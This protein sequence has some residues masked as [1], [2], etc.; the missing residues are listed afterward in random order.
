MYQSVKLLLSILVFLSVSQ[1]LYSQNM[2]TIS[3]Y[4]IVY[5]KPIYGVMVFENSQFLSVS[6]QEGKC[7]INK[8]VK[9]I[10]C[11]YPG[12]NDTLISITGNENCDIFLEANYNL[13]K[14]VEVDAKYD[15]KKHLIRLLKESQQTAYKIDTVLYYS[16]V[17]VNTLTDTNQVEILSGI[18]R[19]ENKG[20]SKK[21]NLTFLSGINNYYN[22]IN[23]ELYPQLRTSKIF[24]TLFFNILYPAR[25]KKLKNKYEIENPIQIGKDSLC[26]PVY[27]KNKDVSTDFNVINFVNKKISSREFAVQI[28]NNDRLNKSYSRTDYLISPISIPK[29]INS[30]RSFLL[31]NGETV[32]NSIELNLIEDPGIKEELSVFIFNSS[33]QKLVEIAKIKFPDIVIPSKKAL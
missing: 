27:S 6:N 2:R 13:I 29:Y 11:K 5:E 33:C 3:F 16:F 9:E 18:L 1:N 28:Q 15:A 17:E 7:S 24:P 21:T 25:I 4:D 12:Y 10:Y 14:E 30:S 19:V 32:T 23:E 20:Y 31:D 8:D 22:S 26:F